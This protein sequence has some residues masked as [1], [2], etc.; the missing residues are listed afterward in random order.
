MARSVMIVDEVQSIPWDLLE[1]A[2]RMLAQVCEAFGS[3][4]VLCT[5]T[6][7]PIDLLPTFTEVPSRVPVAEL[8]GPIPGS[9]P[10][11]DRVRT[12][13]HAEPMSWDDVAGLVAAETSATGGQALAVVNTIADAEALHS[14]LAGI[15][16]LSYLST[17][18]CPAHRRERIDRIADRLAAGQPVVLVSTQMI[19]AG[20]DVDFPIG[21]RAIGPL[22]SIAQVAGRVNRHGTRPD[23][24]LHVFAPT[25][26][27][28]PPGDYR[29]A[30]DLTRQLIERGIDPL[31][32]D[33]VAEFY[34]LFAATRGITDDRQINR[35]RASLDFETV[36]EKFEL[37]TD[38][39][40][41]VVVAWDGFDPFSLAAGPEASAAQ[42]RA[43]IR[44]AAPFAVS[45]RRRAFDLAARAGLTEAIPGVPLHAWIG[46]YSGATG[47]DL[48][49]TDRSYHL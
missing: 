36:A 42:V 6:Q 19:E 5:A 21:F 34:R 16:G 24:V 38:D 49:S 45:L 30:T 39:T 20:V 17:M 41:G 25:N 15:A 1:P 46:P 9:R 40:V 31:H 18:L 35:S 43:K 13:S 7:P 28:T 2:T 4:V 27:T 8:V 3:T 12:R 32:P 29:I 33:A 37:I 26:G 22:T 44:A 10:D 23:G 47:V 11:R 48:P 14:L